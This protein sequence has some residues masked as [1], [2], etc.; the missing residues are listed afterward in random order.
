MFVSPDV[1]AMIIALFA[2]T[3]TVLGGVAGMLAR[4]S[5]ALE[6]RFDRIDDRFDRIEGDLVEMKVA[7][8]R[9]EGPIPT[10]RLGHA[11]GAP[12]ER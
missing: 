12:G 10:L 3:L 8:A 5:K 9:L 2:F 1:L 4:Q 6:S 7:I 11:R